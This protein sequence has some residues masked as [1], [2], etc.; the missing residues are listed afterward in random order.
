MDD[1]AIPLWIDL[2]GAGVGAIQ[3]AMFAVL[4]DDDRNEFDVLAPLVFALVVGLGG[5]MLRDV[6][7]GQLPV[8]LSRDWYLVVVVGAGLGGM[9]AASLLDRVRR[10]VDVLDAA[11]VALFVVLGTLKADRA[12]LSFA[13]VVLLGT[14][15]GVGGGVLRDVLARR[16][17]EVVQRG[18]PYAVLAL[19]GS[20]I[21][22]GMTAA[23][24]TQAA[25]GTSA[26]LFVLVSRVLALRREWR[27]PPP[28]TLRVRD[29]PLRR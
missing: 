1:V 22:A 14:I 6:L 17:V 10:T 25:A 20:A 16:P 5:G 19:G 3:G 27:T 28:P 29:R 12:G 13:P 7:L 23:G 24:T 18:E 2:A 21:F 11:T 9:L 8:A 4:V 15:T 26:F